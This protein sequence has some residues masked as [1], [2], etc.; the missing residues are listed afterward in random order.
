MDTKSSMEGGVL[1]DLESGTRSVINGQEASLGSSVGQAK[2]VLN[3]VW[4]G[5]VSIDGSIKG[6]ESV[7]SGNSNVE[8]P[9]ANG[10]TLVDKRFGAERKVGSLEN[11]TGAEKPKKKNCKKPPKPPR[12]PNSP[13]LDASDRKL[14]RE[15]SELAMLKRARI[16]RMKAL[17]KMKNGKSFSSSNL[18]AL[19]ITTLFCLVIIWQGLLSRGRSTLSFHGSPESSVGTRTALISVQFYHNCS[20]IGS[21]DSSS[22]SPN[23]EPVS[24]VDDHGKTSRGAG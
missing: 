15:I 10:G 24:G 9:Q 12:P 3:R 1:I 14:I 20:A 19:I 6:E 18:G 7:H 23:V 4:S 11:K 21:H 8:G 5:F 17:K 22:A 16:E 2:K 13:T